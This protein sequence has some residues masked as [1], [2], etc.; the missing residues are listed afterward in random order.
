MTETET[1]IREKKD[2]KRITREGKFAV[3]KNE[4]VYGKNSVIRTK[5][6]AVIACL[7]F[8]VVAE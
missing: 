1:Q 5:S 4:K 6:I 3:Q 7:V 2:C 8:L